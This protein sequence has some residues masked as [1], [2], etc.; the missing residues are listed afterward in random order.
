MNLARFFK[1]P[2]STL[3]GYLCEIRKDKTLMGLGLEDEELNAIY[4]AI[5]QE[6]HG[7]S[8]RINL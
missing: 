6:E 5:R 1:I 4:S 8:N 7:K 3:R 2:E